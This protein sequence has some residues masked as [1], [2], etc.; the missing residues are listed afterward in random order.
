MQLKKR[1]LIVTALLFLFTFGIYPIIWFYTTVTALN[2]DLDSIGSSKKR[3]S[4]IPAFLIGMVTFGLYFIYAVYVWCNSL[5]ELADSK[6]VTITDPIVI[7][8]VYLFVPL[9]L[10][11]FQ[12][13]VNKIAEAN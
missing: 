6:K 3:I 2:S 9:G 12:S 4:F 1:D 5:K 13:N 8:I 7:F 11:L 10:L